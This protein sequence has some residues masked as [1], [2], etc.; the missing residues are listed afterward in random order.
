MSEL[1]LIEEQQELAHCEAVGGGLAVSPEHLF[2]A[3]QV[4][5]TYEYLMH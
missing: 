3:K 2:W 1:L 4:V 5:I